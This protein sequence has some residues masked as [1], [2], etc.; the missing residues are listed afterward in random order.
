MH[1]LNRDPHFMHTI[2]PSLSPVTWEGIRM[3]CESKRVKGPMKGGRFGLGFKAVFHITGKYV[4]TEN[5]G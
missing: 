3:L 1:I 5:N 2:M 4:Y